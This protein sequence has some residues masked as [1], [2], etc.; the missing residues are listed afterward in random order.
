M[1][2]P[3]T[4]EE[5]ARLR[6][7]AIRETHAL[8]GSAMAERGFLVLRLLDMVERQEEAVRDAVEAEREA[9]AKVAEGAFPFAATD[10]ERSILD[11]CIQIA[12]RIRA[13]S[14]R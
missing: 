6:T 11:M 1:D 14:Q 9:C 4:R 12:N 13:R 8:A 5:L 2:K 3:L 10:Q 7:W